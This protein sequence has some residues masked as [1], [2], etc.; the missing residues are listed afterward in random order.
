MTSAKLRYFISFFIYIII[1]VLIILLQSTGMMTLQIGTVST[2]LILPLTLYAGFYFGQYAGAVFGLLMGALTD[3][4]SSVLMYNTVLLTLV[5]FFA[6]VFITY[7]F[8][9]NFA[10]ASVLACGSSVLYFFAKWV[11][12]YAFSDPATM[13]VLTHFSL[14]SSVYTAVFGVLM[15]FPLD[16]FFKK[17]PVS[18][19]RQ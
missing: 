10:A 2:V 6:G 9:R 13:F 15:Y 14:P 1:G 19:T 12:V 7:L 18:T 8:N 16:F 5:G 4:F 3:I 11:I 17:I